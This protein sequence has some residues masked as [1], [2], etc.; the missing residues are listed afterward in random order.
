V[1]VGE[2]DALLVAVGLDEADVVAMPPHPTSANPNET[3]TRIDARR[4][5]LAIFMVSP[6]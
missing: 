5:R 6:I 3:A 2:E 1:A 4:A